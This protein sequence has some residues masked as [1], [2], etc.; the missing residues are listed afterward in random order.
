[1]RATRIEQKRRGDS[2]VRRGT[3]R[4]VHACA[5]AVIVAG[6]VFGGAVVPGETLTFPST[7]DEVKQ[8]AQIAKQVESQARLVTDPAQVARL[9]RIGGVMDRV[10][11]RQDLTYHFQIVASPVVNSFAIPGGWVYVTEGMMQFVRTDDE[12]AAVLGHELT[13]I[14]HRHY[15]I[16]QERLS[17]MMPA[18]IIGLAIAV[19]AQSPGPLVA[20][21]AVVQG[22][23]STYQ[24]D[25]EEDADLTSV[26]DLMKT[27]YSP[28]AMLTVMEHL[29]QT[30]RLSGEPSVAGTISADHPEP[31]DR[32]AY[33]QADLERLHVPIIRRIPEGYLRITMD[34]PAASG[35]QPVTIRVDGR[36][37]LT[38][39]TT[40]GGQTPAQRAQAVAARLNDFFNEDPA[41]YDVHVSTLLGRTSVLGREI[42]L[43]DVTAEDA[44][45]ARLEP[46]AFAQSVR[47]S[48]AQAIDDAPYNRGY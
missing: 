17:H 13:H 33:L 36:P 14:N 11:E 1:M 16:Q 15:Y 31:E 2:L 3:L 5:A 28:V 23:M 24:R 19:L 41:P 4:V 30:E 34:P 18:M 38:L 47:S 46:G 43:Y 9:T 12:L 45:Y 39:G 26:A 44:A 21:Q 40:V 8:G 48:L 10:V 35:D 32:V 29:A 7:A 27:S 25:L 42:D 22:T 37:V 20:E 6:M